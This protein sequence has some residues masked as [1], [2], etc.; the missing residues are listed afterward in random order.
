MTR[1]AMTYL[2]LLTASLLYLTVLPVAHA[3]F[4]TENKKV[5]LKVNLGGGPVGDFL[6]EDQVLDVEDFAK[7]VARIDIHNTDQPQI[8]Q[9]Q[10]FAR[11]QDMTFRIPVPDGIYSV[12]LLFAETYEPACVHGGRVF[13]IAL[14]T[15]VSGVTKIIDSFDVFQ[16]AGCFSAHGKRFDK[17]PSK[18]GIVVHLAHKQQHPS[19]CGFIVDGFPIPKGDGSEF[20]AIARESP[21]DSSAN[22]RP[23]SATHAISSSAPSSPS[24]PGNALAPPPSSMHAIPAPAGMPAPPGMASAHG[25]HPPPPS[26]LSSSSEMPP[27]P[28]S[29]PGFGASGT[30][31]AP[32]AYGRPARRRRRRR[33]LLSD[34]RNEKDNNMKQDEKLMPVDASDVVVSISGKR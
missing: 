32:P 25:P 16:S 33:R 12:T 3:Q 21:S 31:G 34:D 9:S 11:S 19:L 2:T 13:D 18:N 4:A 15:P 28:V 27:A 20:K 5:L 30:Y 8:F 6:G 23:I 26:S 17:V 1:V 22:A 7:N 14:G 24:S 10:R 29:P